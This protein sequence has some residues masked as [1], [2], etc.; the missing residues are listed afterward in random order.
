MKLFEDFFCHVLHVNEFAPNE[1][2]NAAAFRERH[3]LVKVE[4]TATIVL[5]CDDRSVGE[6]AQIAGICCFIDGVVQIEDVGHLSSVHQRVD[7]ISL[8]VV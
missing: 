6:P 2:G 7:D 8:R 5:C 3:C 1:N 4:A